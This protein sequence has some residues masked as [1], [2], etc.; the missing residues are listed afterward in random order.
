[1]TRI[2]FQTLTFQNEDQGGPN[3]YRS[4]FKVSF[5]DDDVK[6]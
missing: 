6:K 4:I 2:E 1:M 3:H 5:R